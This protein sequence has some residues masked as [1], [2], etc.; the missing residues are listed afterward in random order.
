MDDMVQLRDVRKGRRQGRALVHSGKELGPARL[1]QCVQRIEI[2]TKSLIGLE[3]E[4]VGRD[5]CTHVDVHKIC[6]GNLREE[7]GCRGGS[8]L[9]GRG[10]REM[11]R[12]WVREYLSGPQGRG[13]HPLSGPVGRFLPLETQFLFLSSSVPNRFYPLQGRTGLHE[14]LQPEKIGLSLDLKKHP[15]RR[16]RRERPRKD[17]DTRVLVPRVWQREEAVGSS[18][19]QE[20]KEGFVCIYV[21]KGPLMFDHVRQTQKKRKMREDRE[22]DIFG[23]DLAVRTVLL[24]HSKV[25]LSKEKKGHGIEGTKNGTQQKRVRTPR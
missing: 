14:T 12:V 11:D 17:P 10:S 9:R 25:V 3:R 2:H 4:V 19:P 20:S 5:G 24:A 13:K 7:T 23:L 1:I 18:A 15:L 6:R 8:S 21:D 22:I 16:R